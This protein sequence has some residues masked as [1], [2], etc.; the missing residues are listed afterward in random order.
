MSTN[1]ILLVDD[2][3]AARKL[4]RFALERAGLRVVEAETGESALSLARSERPQLVIQ[5]LAL[6]DIDGFDLVGRLR[7]IRQDEPLCVLAF[8]GLISKVDQSRVVAAG[9]DDVIPKP[10]DPSTLVSIVESHLPGR[11][12]L[13]GRFGEGKRLVLADDDV[14]QLRLTVLRLAA[15]GFDIVEAKDGAEALARIR[16]SPPH[17]VVS[18]VMMPRVDGFDLALSL[19]R[20]PALTHIPLVLL[21]SSYVEES[22]RH[23]ARRA[24]ADAFVLRTP[25]MRELVETLFVTMRG[26]RGSRHRS[27]TEEVPV[28]ELVKQHAERVVR[29]LDRQVR[30]NAALMRRC[31]ALSTELSIVTRIS[32]AV[33]K[34]RNVE[35][36]LDDVLSTCFDSEG[37]S[38]G[39]LYLLGAGQTQ[40]LRVRPLGAQRFSSHDLE[41]FF[42]QREWLYDV[43][44]KGQTQVL[45]DTSEA[46]PE[47][48]KVLER[49]SAESALLVP[50][51]HMNKAMGALFMAHTDA[52][53]AVDVLQ[54]RVFAQGVS[55]QITLALALANAFYDLEAAEREATEQRS[56]VRDQAARWR[57]LVE[58]AP[59]I[60]MNLGREGEIL[61]IN[62]PPTGFSS[63]ELAGKSWH[64]FAAP[65]HRETRGQTL[66]AVFATG[67]PATIETASPG[68]DGEMYWVESHL[69]PIFTG[70]EVSG[71][72]V[73]ERDVTLKKQTEAQLIVSDRMASVGTLAA[74]VAHEINNPLASVMANLDLA[75]RDASELV[76]NVG[77]TT[78][79]LDELNDAREAAERVRR[80][81][82][83]LKI[84]SR[85]DDD[86]RGPVDV[87]RVLE[88]TLRMAWNE[89]RHRARLVK[90]YHK[91]PLVEANESRLGQVFLNLL[92]NAAQAIEEGKASRNEIRVKT[93]VDAQGMVVVS[94]S[95]TGVGIPEGLRSRLFTPFVTTKPAGV[96]T[97][98]GLSICHRIV[99]SLGGQIKVDSEVG[100]GTEFRVVLPQA[101]PD[102][103]VPESPST[104]PKSAPRRRGRILVV[105]DEPL[106]TKV[107]RRTL[108]R[109]HD[110]ETLNSAEE[111]LTRI[112]SGERFDVI[113]CD[114]MMPQVTGMDFHAELTDDFPEQA[115]K[116]VFLSGGAFTKR[117]RDFLESVSNHRV[118]KPIDAQGLKA[119]VND[120]LR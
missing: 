118:E 92:V 12:S 65:E 114:L 44:R 77:Y 62:R 41:D 83:D 47:C 52:A 61:F 84:F 73:I 4:V 39:A 5:D 23:L 94:I 110:V 25:D 9:F 33:L 100:K 71:V 32:E 98:L 105:D 89:I 19:R 20:D 2:H 35:A 15:L 111:A 91:T 27:S 11:A 120:M 64:D 82:K 37:A 34:Q 7:G 58:N 102:S 13:A 8:S 43:M 51:V 48:R 115:K 81:V 24:G 36:E 74:G 59:D 50:L 96:G 66:A 6:P 56:V 54:W 85:V 67:T 79:L 76:E 31:S 103:V 14:A 101:K 68:R 26:D 109:E 55:N 63:E 38:T 29:Q 30:H 17:V 107:V 112:R 87:E 117:A 70:H 57:A 116:M 53:H 75:V 28:E 16:E 106:I 108:G 46:S 1:T 78:E 72:A 40:T 49:T 3:A 45:V 10:C 97:G 18:D 95:D 60:V 88:S 113:L 69:G 90:D 119:L 93:H 22:D 42:G 86:T 80:I 99:T 104:A 21:S